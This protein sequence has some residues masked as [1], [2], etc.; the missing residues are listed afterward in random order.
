MATHK[1]LLIP[2]VEEILLKEIGE[3]NIPPLKWTK[4]SSTS[5]AS[6]TKYKFL[7]DIGDFTEMA[8]VEFELL[9][10]DVEKQ[11]YIPPKYHHLKTIYNVG[12]DISGNQYQ[13][14]KSDMKTLLK[15]L[16]TIVDIVKDFINTNKID[17]LFIQGTPKELDNKDISKKSN[18]YK[19]FIQK[20]LNQIPNYGSD[21]HRDGFILIKIK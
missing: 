3:A 9:D 6:P 14:A 7:V 12:Y 13:F 5:K 11:Y 4:V 8:T 18:L 17:G 16:S 21:T 1:T 20:Q 19:A 15:I 10:D 2:L